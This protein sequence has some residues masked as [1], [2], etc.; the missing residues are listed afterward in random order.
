MGE[1]IHMEPILETLHALDDGVP[2]QTQMLGYSRNISPTIQ[3]DFQGIQKV[4]AGALLVVLDEPAKLI[5]QGIGERIVGKASQIPSE[6]KIA[7]LD[8]WR[9]SWQMAANDKR[10]FRF[11]PS[12]RSSLDI[13][14]RIAQSNRQS[15]MVIV[16]THRLNQLAQALL[17][18]RN[19]SAFERD[20]RRGEVLLN[21]EER[22][23]ELFLK[24]LVQHN[25]DQLVCCLALDPLHL[26]PSLDDSHDMRLA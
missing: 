20:E 14:A 10:L 7:S 3:V 4:A 9:A 8:D 2:V 22:I 12:S 21:K 24:A 26:I 15:H 1:K 11:V 16:L 19:G 25:R 18:A 23:R 13:Q 6:A 17:H 5:L